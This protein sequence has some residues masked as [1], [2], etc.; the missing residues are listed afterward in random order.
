MAL[1]PG[2]AAAS[3][4]RFAAEL[5]SVIAGDDTGSRMFWE[6]VD[7]GYVES[8]DLGFHD[9]DGEGS[10][11]TYLSCDPEDIDDE[12]LPIPERVVHLLHLFSWVSSSGEL[13]V[14]SPC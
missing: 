7:P 4:D 5:L 10:F 14:S 11:L 9:F 13:P 2:P 12:D 8:A 6:L 1:C 3:R